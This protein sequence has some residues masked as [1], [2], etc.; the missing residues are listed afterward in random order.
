MWTTCLI[1]VPMGTIIKNS[2]SKSVLPYSFNLYNIRYPSFFYKSTCL[3]G[4]AGAKAKYTLQARTYSTSSKDGSS[5][6]CVASAIFLTLTKRQRQ[7]RY[8]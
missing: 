8:P 6:G 1:M 4:V 5:Y 7:T 3:G 2:I